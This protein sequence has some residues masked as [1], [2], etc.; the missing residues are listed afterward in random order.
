[1]RARVSVS[2]GLKWERLIST[3]AATAVREG[4]KYASERSTEDAVRASS[5]SAGYWLASDSSSGALCSK[6]ERQRLAWAKKSAA[7][8]LFSQLA[9]SG[10]ICSTLESSDSSWLVRERNSK[11]SLRRSDSSNQCCR[12]RAS[13]AASSYVSCM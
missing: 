13:H 3:S 10:A 7:A 8:G 1:M 6:W 2:R 9:A 11:N 4:S 5:V 12:K